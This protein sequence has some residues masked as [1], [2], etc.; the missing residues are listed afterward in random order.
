[1]PNQNPIQGKF[2]KSEKDNSTCVKVRLY[3][4]PV[5][6]NNQKRHNF[7]HLPN[8]MKTNVNYA[9]YL[10]IKNMIVFQQYF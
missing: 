4:L 3:V 9:L 6:E 1:M 5:Q 10:L 2:V 7:F 8:K